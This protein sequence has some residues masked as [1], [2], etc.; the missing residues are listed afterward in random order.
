[1]HRLN[2]APE[3]RDWR[4]PAPEKA[5]SSPRTILAKEG[6]EAPAIQI[7]LDRRTGSN[8]DDIQPRA[9]WKTKES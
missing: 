3:N 2:E 8:L 7:A 6:I 1:M 9:D 5:A 4:T